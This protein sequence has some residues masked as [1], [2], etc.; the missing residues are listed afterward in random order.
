M[1]KRIAV[2]WAKGERRATGT[3]SDACFR[4]GEE[5]HWARDCT[6]GGGGGYG[7]GGGGGYGGRGRSPPRYGRGYG[8]GPIF[9]SSSTYCSS[10][11]GISP[12]CVLQSLLHL[13]IQPQP[14]A[15]SGT[16]QP[17]AQA[18]SQPVPQA[19]TQPVPQAWSLLALAQA[20]PFAQAQPLAP[21]RPIAFAAQPRREEEALPHAL[22]RR[23]AFA[24]ASPRQPVAASQP[25]AQQGKPVAQEEPL[26]QTQE[27]ERLAQPEPRHQ[28]R[29]P[30]AL[31]RPGQRRQRRRFRR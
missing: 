22:A 23:P 31:A 6:R 30:L 3:R 20:Q 10:F 28:A 2:E 17:F 9:A 7:P 18:R 14:F 8:S 1:G 12:C 29:Q 24:F 19:W 11:T 25:L 26:A 15:P 13:Q 5:G 16:L 21:T 27:D 4:C